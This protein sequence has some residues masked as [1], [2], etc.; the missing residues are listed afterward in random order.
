MNS[1]MIGKIDKAHRYAAERD[2]FYVR[3]FSITVRGD[4]A[5]HQ[6]QYEN[7]CW[8][9][10]CDFFAHHGRCA[11]TMSLELVLGDMM[12]EPAQAAVA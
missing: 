7:G 2:R 8:S 10:E 9:C 11:H 1:G 5:D 4:N 3:S 6:V 12:H